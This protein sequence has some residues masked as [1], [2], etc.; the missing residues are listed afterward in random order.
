MALEL[1]GVGGLVHDD[2][3]PQAVHRNPQPP[4]RRDDVP[5]EEKDLARLPRPL[6]GPLADDEGARIVLAQNAGGEEAQEEPHLSRERRPPEDP[7][8]IAGARSD[9]SQDRLQKR[10]EALDVKIYPL[11]P[12][13]DA[14]RTFALRQAYACK[15][16]ERPIRLL[17]PRPI[18]K[19]FYAVGRYLRPRGQGHG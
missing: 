16:L 12:V 11:G 15:L 10:P 18:I 19:G 8:H 3:E 1:Q 14:H 2:P 4:G 5:V 7:S 17:D 9:T 6:R 13:G